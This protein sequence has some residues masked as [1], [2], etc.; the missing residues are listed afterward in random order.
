MNPFDF[1]NS[2]NHTKENLIVDDITEKAYNPYITNHQLS[3]FSDTVHIV[4]V[5]NK[6][7]HL[8]KKLQYDFLL[9]IVRKRKRF[10]KWNK[11]DDVGNLEV[12]KEYY[13]Y[14][15]EK[16]K[17]ILPLLSPEA[18]EIIKQRMYKGGTK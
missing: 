16:A 14:S 4:N 7:H 5:L 17:S 15:N 13:G 8:D 1:I 12:V 3:Y 10:T 9:N 11:P 18:I 2:I 6:Y